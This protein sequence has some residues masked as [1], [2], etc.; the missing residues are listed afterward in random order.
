MNAI[1][2]EGTPIQVITTLSEWAGPVFTEGIDELNKAYLDFG[3]NCAP[4]LDQNQI[5]IIQEA[6]FRIAQSIMGF[7]GVSNNPITD[8]KYTWCSELH[9]VIT[10]KSRIAIVLPFGKDHSLVQIGRA[11][12]KSEEVRSCA[13]YINGETPEK[14][15]KTILTDLQKG[16]SANTKKQ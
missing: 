12:K 2:R 15:I 6:I 11:H 16:F 14:S 3:E 9:F 7:A 1:I 4:A 10:K 5:I 8:D 13:V